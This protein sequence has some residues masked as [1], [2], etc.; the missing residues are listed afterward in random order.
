MTS[1]LTSSLLI[2]LGGAI[3]AVLRYWS[4]RWAAAVLGPSWPWGT[5]LVNVLGGFAI[6]AVVALS[7]RELLSPASRLFL[8]TG[9]LGGFTTFSAFSLEV[10]QLAERGA[11]TSAVVYI[12]VSVLLS[13]GGVFFG[14]KIFA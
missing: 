5:L 1:A 11:V 6:G 2:A 14:L 12:L 13:V 7:S 3:G 4:G 8:T 10:V 9:L